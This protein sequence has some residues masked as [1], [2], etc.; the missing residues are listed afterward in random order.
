MP[1]G[2]KHKTKANKHENTGDEKVVKTLITNVTDKINA[3]NDKQLQQNKTGFSGSITAFLVPTVEP[4]M[5]ATIIDK[6]YEE[7]NGNYFIEGVQGSFDK[8]G[9]R[10]NVQISY[11][12]KNNG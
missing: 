8:S 2:T 10:I 4:G 9:G 7:R 6:K 3:I 5:T 12:L 1:N 11:A